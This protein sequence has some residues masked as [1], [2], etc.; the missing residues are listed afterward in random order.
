MSKL[1]NL[2]IKWWTPAASSNPHITSASLAPLLSRNTA[3]VTCSHA[4]NI[5]G[6][7]TSVREIADLVHTIPGALLCV[8][9]V[10]YAPHRPLD[11]Q[12]LGV[13]F[14]C[15]SWYKVFGPHVAQLYARREAQ[16]AAMSSLGHYFKGG[17]TLEDKLG[18]AAASYEL[19]AS[20]P[21][22]T[23]YL[24]KQGWANLVRHEE[25]IQEVLLAFLRSKPDVYTVQGV[26]EGDA[27]LRVPVI[28]FTVKG[29]GS[30]EVVEAVEKKTE[31]GF[32]WGH[33]YSKRLVDDVLG[34]GEEGVVRVSLVHYNTVDEVERFVKAL[35]EEVCSK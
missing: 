27:K 14:Y 17:A 24:E 19:A 34:L 26:P 22:V 8:D 4:S 16:D 2:T 12:A 28:S 20:L 21:V 7:I 35:D 33:F 25:V 29:R 11:M 3:L 15:F 6:S 5:L 9:G 31:F 1:L 18:L 23:A 30:R 10:A 13:D 32:R